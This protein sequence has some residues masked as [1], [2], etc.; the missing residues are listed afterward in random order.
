M[1]AEEVIAAVTRGGGTLRADGDQVRLVGSRA[2]LTA[3]LVAALREHKAELLSLLSQ[4]VPHGERDHR[5]VGRMRL[6][7]FAA[8]ELVI[9]IFSGVVGEKVY[10]ASDNA[11]LDIDE[12]GHYRG[13]VVYRASELRELVGASADAVRT[14]HEVKK[15]FGGSIIP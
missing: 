1:N 3:E 13:C 11:K 6:V 14:I 8:A 9:T 2:L 4:T 7:D 10:F 5:A 12:D 15:V